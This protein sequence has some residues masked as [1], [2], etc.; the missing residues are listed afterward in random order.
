MSGVDINIR[1]DIK[2]ITRDLDRLAYQQLPYATALALTGLAKRVQAGETANLTSVFDRPVPFTMK[3]FGVIAARKDTLTATV[4]AKDIQAKYLAPSEFGETQYL[5]AGKKIRTPADI[6]LNA[7]GNIPK[8]KIAQLLARPDVF[9]ATIKGVNGIWQ[10]PTK[11]APQG[12]VRGK[13]RG[14]PK[15]V[16]RL[17]LLLAFTAPKAVKTKLEYHQHAQMIVDQY[18][19]TEFAWAMAQAKATAK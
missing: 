15:P 11:T 2:S 4:F 3:A 14:G 9:M 10:R 19:Q 6:Q 12:A 7:Y 18:W 8:G 13:R 16:D 1:A 5:G 17:T